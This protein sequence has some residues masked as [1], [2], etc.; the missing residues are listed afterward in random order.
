M[1]KIKLFV[2]ILLIGL[3]LCGCSAKG[4]PTMENYRKIKV[5]MTP[6]EV[7]ALM[8]KPDDTGNEEYFEF[9]YWLL[10]RKYYQVKSVHRPQIDG[11]D[12]DLP[13]V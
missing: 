10:H 13:K 9:Q 6:K 2:V 8:G 12:K 11:K 1:R 3:C 7:H 4:E 5:G